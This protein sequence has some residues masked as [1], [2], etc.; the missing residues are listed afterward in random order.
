MRKFSSNHLQE[1]FCKSL[2]EAY[3]RSFYLTDD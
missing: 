2:P 1:G 3:D